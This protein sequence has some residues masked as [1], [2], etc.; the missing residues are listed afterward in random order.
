MQAPIDIT[1]RSMDPSAAVE[2]SIRKWAARL[3]E[4]CDTIERCEVVVELPHRRHLHGKTFQVH[5]RVTIPD[6][7]IAI[8][9][10][11]GR[12]HGHED[13]YVAISDAFRAARRQLGDRAQIRRHE[14]KLH[15]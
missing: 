9:R 11:P 14:V 13:V 10:D 5:L 4:C 1:F 2:E 3:D 12:D 15:A 7:T 6:G 8:T